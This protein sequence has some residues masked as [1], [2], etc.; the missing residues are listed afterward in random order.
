MVAVRQLAREATA[1][2]CATRASLRD[3]SLVLVAIAS[4]GAISSVDELSPQFFFLPSH[5]SHHTIDRPL[6]LTLPTL[7][8]QSKQDLYALL[9]ELVPSPPSTVTSTSD[10]KH[11]H[12]AT[13][14]SVHFDPTAL[15]PPMV[16]LGTGSWPSDST[17]DGESWQADGVGAR[18]CITM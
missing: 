12:T 16:F 10:P 8:I 15:E 13:A 6:T 2:F 7:S 5:T 17:H 18:V 3:A 14:H 4:V 9:P 1:S 11:V